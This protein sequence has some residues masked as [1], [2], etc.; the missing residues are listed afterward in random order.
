[1]YRN[2]H[3]LMKAKGVNLEPEVLSWDFN[4]TRRARCFQA[5]APRSPHAGGGRIHCQEPAGRGECPRARL[6]MSELF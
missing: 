1:M 3:I 6:K 2:V 5:S 4:A